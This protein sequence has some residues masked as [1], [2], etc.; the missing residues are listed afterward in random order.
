MPVM[1]GKVCA[2]RIREV[3]KSRGIRPCM[4]VIISG[5]CVDSEIRECLDEKGLIKADAFL[6][7]PV[8]LDELSRAISKHY[9]QT[10]D[11]YP[12]SPFL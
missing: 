7:K 9:A 11:K 8:S 4:I 12:S 5:N 1:N 3:E 6:K 2:Q 10:L